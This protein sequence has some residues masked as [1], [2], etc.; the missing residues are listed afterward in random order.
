MFTGII[1]AQARIIDITESGI[2]LS[3]PESFTD[4]TIGASISVSGVCLSVTSFDDTS[5]SF[6]VVQETKDRST[7]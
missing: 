3:K 1:E 4:L 5:I 2:I 7:L 6:D